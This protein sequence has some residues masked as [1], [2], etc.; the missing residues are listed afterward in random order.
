VAVIA[1]ERFK[2]INDSLGAV[3]GDE[4]LRQFSNRLAQCV[5]QRDTVGRMGGDDFALIMGD[6]EQVA[7]WGAAGRGRDRASGREVIEAREIQVQRPAV[8]V[9]Q[10]QA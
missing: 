4:L 10:A 2:N 8:G 5:R 3:L 9:H 1:L 6:L 7:R